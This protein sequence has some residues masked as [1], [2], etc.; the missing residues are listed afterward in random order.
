M[1]GLIMSGPN[2]H[3]VTQQ[4]TE[5]VTPI[6]MAFLGAWLHVTL[7]LTY[8]WGQDDL[9]PRSYMLAAIRL[10]TAL[11]IGLVFIAIYRSYSD[12]GASNFPWGMLLTAFAVG[13]FP[14]ETLRSMIR[15][16]NGV[17]GSWIETATKTLTFKG[18]KFDPVEYPD[19]VGQYPLTKLE[20]MTIWSEGRFSQEGI[21]DIRSLAMCDL[22]TMVLTT[23]F[24][25]QALIDWID[26]AILWV[27]TGE[28]QPVL[29]AANIR[30]AT[31]LIAIFD[32]EKQK[33]DYHSAIIEGLLGI[34]KS[35]GVKAG[36]EPAVTAPAE[37][38]EQV[39]ADQ[40]PKPKLTKDNLAVIVQAIKEDCNIQYL[41]RFWGIKTGKKCSDKATQLICKKNCESEWQ[42]RVLSL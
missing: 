7:M 6:S 24:S 21:D 23:P 22:E 15:V 14:V 40:Y 37:A 2:I 41:M 13:I 20:E 5:S 18:S 35:N 19:I 30:R 25:S 10:I 9:L 3:G 29:K 34:D 12:T 32:G 28:H 11:V 33:D 36:Q 17:L 39:V 8:R 42:Y 16:A 26:Q 27:Y 38:A 1:V 31:Q 4:L